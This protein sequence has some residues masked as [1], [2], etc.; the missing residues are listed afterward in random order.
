MRG[1]MAVDQ[2]SRIEM[3]LVVCC[4]VS[5]ALQ[6]I[7]LY[8]RLVEWLLFLARLFWPEICWNAPSFL[9]LRTVCF[10]VE[11]CPWYLLQYLLWEWIHH[12][13]TIL[14][15]RSVA[16]SNN[17]PF[18]V[19]NAKVIWNESFSNKPLL[20]SYQSVSHINIGDLARPLI[21]RF[22]WWVLHDK[23]WMNECCIVCIRAKSR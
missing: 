22:E 2:Y 14:W 13:S 9:Q 23:C 15:K 5:I 19:M 7:E 18:F 20:S 16:C 12:Y 4:I 21:F 3:L 10:W 6:K 17:P 8:L 11:Y 1:A